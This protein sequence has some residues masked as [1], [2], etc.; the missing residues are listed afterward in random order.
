MAAQGLHLLLTITGVINI[1]TGVESSAH[2][3]MTAQGLESSATLVHPRSAHL[4]SFT[5][6][7]AFRIIQGVAHR[8]FV[9]AFAFH[10]AHTRK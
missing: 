3:H 4:H 7:L 9:R 1:D 10:I 2:A 5:L 6:V 8:R